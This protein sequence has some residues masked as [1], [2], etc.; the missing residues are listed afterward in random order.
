M[1]ENGR[2]EMIERGMR[3]EMD[4][5]EGRKDEHVERGVRENG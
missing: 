3:E 4:G 1:S 5:K 2:E